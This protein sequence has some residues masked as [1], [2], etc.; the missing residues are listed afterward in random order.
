VEQKRGKA[1]AFVSGLVC[2]ACLVMTLQASGGLGNLLASLRRQPP[3][4]VEEPPREE[5]KDPPREE[6][7]DP[8][9][10]EKKEPPREEKKDGPGKPPPKDGTKKPPPP[11]KDDKGKTPPKDGAKKPPPPKKE[12]PPPPPPEDPAVKLARLQKELANPA[13]RARAAAD[14]GAMGGKART[15]S[16]LLFTLAM[17]E[18]ANRDPYL[19][20]LARVHPELGEPLKALFKA[21]EQPARAAATRRL[22]EL[23]AEAQ[24]VF[25]VLLTRARRGWESLATGPGTEDHPLPDL[26]A[27]GKL[28]PGNEALIDLLCQIAEVTPDKPAYPAAS[29]L[30][31]HAVA[32][33]QAE[34]RQRPTQR[35]RVLTLLTASLAY[36]PKRGSE[37]D[38]LQRIEAIASFGKEA[39]AAAARLKELT[40]SSN[41][42]IKLKAAEALA[43][44]TE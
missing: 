13:T 28:A 37:V 3:D 16:A 30:V 27:L 44:V 25:P 10:E 18:A 29:L 22:G 38:M 14:L 33:L 1:L 7:K 8:P 31:S 23:G 41:E 12:D 9:K 20:A 5:K 36:E 35:K 24:G 39:S 32:A 2:V 26:E 34:A 6:K 43:K 11:R 21:P 42:R 15:A 40:E 4:P 19:D 17:E